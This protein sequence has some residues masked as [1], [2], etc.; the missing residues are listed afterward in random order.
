MKR[1]IFL[2]PAALAVLFMSSLI[3]IVSPVGNHTIIPV[4][5][6]DLNQISEIEALKIVSNLTEIRQEDL[7]INSNKG[8]PLYYIEQFPT[9]DNPNFQIF[10]GKNQSGKVIRLATFF[11]DSKTG[12]V[13]IKDTNSG[14]IISYRQW[15]ISCNLQ[16]CQN[17]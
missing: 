2:F 8:D 14:Q 9:T 1:S 5:N 13:N 6:S 7:I 17:K 4:P 10:Y 12:Q 15:Q 16:S 11:V 3:I